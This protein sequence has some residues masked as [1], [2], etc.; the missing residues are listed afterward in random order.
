M[1]D[2]RPWMVA[3]LMAGLKSPGGI[4]PAMQ[5]DLADAVRL[6]QE[7]GGEVVWKYGDGVPFAPGYV[8]WL[9]AE[10][11]RLRSAGRQPVPLDGRLPLD[12]GGR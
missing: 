3:P 8:A 4:I 12:T 1:F 2:E 6:R 11:E 9:E 7:Y 10:V 5:S